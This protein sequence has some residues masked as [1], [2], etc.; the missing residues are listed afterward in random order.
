M[1]NMNRK[2]WILTG[3]ALAGV[4]GLAMVAAAQQA[5]RPNDEAWNGPFEVVPVR[6]NIYLVAG[7]GGNITA[8]V[9]PEG[10]LLVDAGRAESADKVLQAINE[11]S[12]DVSSFGQPVTRRSG[13]GGSG[14]VLTGSRPPKPI[15]YIINTSPLPEHT[16]GNAKLAAAG[17]TFTGGNVAG[18][19]GDVGEGAAILSHED[20][21]KRLSDA[22]VP[23][24]GQPTETYFGAYMKLSHF[25]NGEGVM[26][27][28]VANAI[29]DGDTMVYFRGSD[30]IS[31]G[32]IFVMGG[33]PPIDMAKGGSVQGVLA[34]LNKMLEIVVPEFRSEGG[35][36]V[37]P[38]HGRICDTADLA[39]YRDMVTMI[40]DRVQDYMKKG[41]TLDQIKAAKPTEDWDGR[42][43]H[44]PQITSD[45]FVEIV[46]KSLQQGQGKK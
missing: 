27:H 1:L 46:Y 20:T 32:D 29:T 41:M 24:K 33:Y 18:D 3:A 45:A 38:G 12:A 6:G 31:S 43:G 7:A 2:R 37:V 23:I 28:H 34:G 42:F 16:G 36:F 15:R 40:R 8:S 39:Y 26:M 22:K 30:V 25:F 4:A 35:T 9:G 10:V 44:S 19:L 21:L 13:G 14:S 17:K 5:A 11:L